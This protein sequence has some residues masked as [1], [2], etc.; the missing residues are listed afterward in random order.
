MLKYVS[1]FILDI[2]PS[3]VATIVGAYIVNHYIIPRPGADRLA[4]E[5]AAIESRAASPASAKTDARPAEASVD[6]ANRSE[7]GEAGVK[8]GDK[9]AVEKAGLEKAALEKTG[10]E[11]IADPL[12]ASASSR[13]HQPAPREKP[14]AKA[15][16]TPAPAAAPVATASIAP[17]P[18]AGPAADERRDVNDL[19]R[20]AIERQRGA[21]DALSRTPDAV[22]A[23]EPPHGEEA[24]RTVAAPLQQLPPPI[25]VSTPNVESYGANQIS[26]PPPTSDHAGDA[27][28]LRPPA[29]IPAASR[30]IDLQAEAT[31]STRPD[32]T[33][34]AE[35]VLSAARSVFHAVLPK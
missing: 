21:N 12:N 32:R 31:G 3:V 13:R 11:K 19:A 6:V 15:A 20:A 23:A 5:T 9:P 27:R 2:F 22:R 28:H 29:E 33:S 10:L 26:R 35:D 8:A 16:P 4:A 7:P 14:V 25:L 17:A 1:K 34:M 18:E 30:P 24:P